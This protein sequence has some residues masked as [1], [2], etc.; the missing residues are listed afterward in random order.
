VR[1]AG[2]VYTALDVRAARA[3]VTATPPNVSVTVDV[4]SCFAVGTSV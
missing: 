3:Y 1:P 2:I 4:I